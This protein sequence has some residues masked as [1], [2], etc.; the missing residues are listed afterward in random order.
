MNEIIQNF[1]LMPEIL[2]EFCSSND[3]NLHKHCL[4]L[5]L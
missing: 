1:F 5:I 3:Q 2:Q 4:G